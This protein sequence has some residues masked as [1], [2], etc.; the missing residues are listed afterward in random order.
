[1]PDNVP[2]GRVVGDLPPKA[3][4]NPEWQAAAITARNNPLKAVEVAHDVNVVRINSVRQYISP[5]FRTPDGQISVTYRDSK[6]GEDGVRRAT[7]YFTWVPNKG[8]R[9]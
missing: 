8:K 4:T 6:V 9:K 1:M 5:P 2:G 3:S 7:M